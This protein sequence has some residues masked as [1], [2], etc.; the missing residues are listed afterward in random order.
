MFRNHDKNTANDQDP[1]VWPTV[2]QA[3]R[4]AYLFRYRHLPYLF[5]YKF[6][7][8]L[9]TEHFSIDPA[10]NPKIELFFFLTT[11]S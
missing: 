2:A 9:I 10:Q 4:K 8:F 7:G 5:R 6:S 3:A 1:G 11:F